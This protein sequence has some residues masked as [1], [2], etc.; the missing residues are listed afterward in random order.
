MDVY[1]DLAEE[2]DE[3]IKHYDDLKE[4]KLEVER[5]H[6]ENK[7]TQQLL[8]NIGLALNSLPIWFINKL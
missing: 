1:G 6:Q 7:E 4:L 3:R 2:Q 8:I 5:M